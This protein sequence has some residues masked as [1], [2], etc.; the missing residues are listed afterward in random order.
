MDCESLLSEMAREKLVIRYEVEGKRYLEVVNFAKHQRPHFREVQSIIPPPPTGSAPAQDQGS[1]E[2]SLNKAQPSPNKA[3]PS[4]NKARLGEGQPALESLNPR[5]LESLN[6][7]NT[8]CTPTPCGDGLR[9]EKTAQTSEPAKPRAPDA[10]PPAGI[11][12]QE[13]PPDPAPVLAQA[14]S[15]PSKRPS[16]AAPTPAKPSPSV[17][18]WQ[19]YAQAYLTRY[20]VEPVR[21]AKVNGQLAALVGRLGADDAPQ[22]AAFY[23]RHDRRQYQAVGHAVGLLLRDAEQLRTEWATNRV[24]QVAEAPTFQERD[25]LRKRQ[26]W[27]KLTGREHPEIERPFGSTAITLEAE[28]S[29]DRLGICH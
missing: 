20:G 1:A 8:I 7:R 23:L 25:L 12:D 29:Y 16:K 11:A 13:K 18:V 15:S 10:A 24:H 27:E 26:R 19:A 4:L 28:D 9:P 22:V 17:L 6:P 14:A 2:K 21:N 5:I 3:Q